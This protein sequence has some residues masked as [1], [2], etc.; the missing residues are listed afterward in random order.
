MSNV[1]ILYKFC[2]IQQKVSGMY[3]MNIL[4]VLHKNF[5]DFS[6]LFMSIHILSAV[7]ESK[8]SSVATPE[9]TYISLSS[10]ENRRIFSIPI[11]ALKPWE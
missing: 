11:F 7:V 5:P 2:P 4:I 9:N 3:T 8:S 6:R 10:V 1:F